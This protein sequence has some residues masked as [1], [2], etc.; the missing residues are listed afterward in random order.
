LEEEA[1]Q[2][3]GHVHMLLGNH[4]EINLTGIAL[5][6]RGYV[7]LGQFL[8]FLPDKFKQKKNKEFLRKHKIDSLDRMDKEVSQA[9]REFWQRILDDALADQ[10]STARQEYT[11]NFVQTYGK[12]IMSHNTVIRIN[13]IIFVHGGIS[14]DYSSWSLQE[15]N[16]RMRSELEEFSRAVVYGE[17]PQIQRRILFEGFGPLWHRALAQNNDLSLEEELDGILKNYEAR[18][19]IIA[20]TPQIATIENMRKF[21]GKVWIIDTGVSEYYRKDG[22]LVSALIINNGDFFVWKPGSDYEN[23]ASEKQGGAL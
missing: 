21:D 3:G 1:A 11:R 4:E 13:D 22:G 7:T 2:A 12:W 19:M 20:H 15:I 10:N 6:Y 8:D 9:H 14:K 18:H 5:D 16:Q 17:E 23:E